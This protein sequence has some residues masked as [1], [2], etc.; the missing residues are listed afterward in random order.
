MINP[1]KLLSSKI[2][3]QNPWIKVREDA[4]VRP[5]GKNGLFGVVTMK[6]GSTV[7]ALDQDL[8]ALLVRE[9]KFAIDRPS[10]ELVSGGID[11]SET[12]L[13]AAKRELLEETGSTA[14]EWVDFGLLTP[15]TSVVDS[16][17]YM[18][19]AL[20]ASIPKEHHS[21]PDEPLERVVLPFSEVVDMAMRSEITHGAS[22][23]LILKA[24]RYLKV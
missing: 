21:A 8:N 2:V 10:L 13:S 5:D 15:F 23:A 24:A 4:V 16:P 1:F 3:Y 22:C 12:P 11:S 14:S 17:N 6:S 18:Y 9:F 20:G 7:L 19:L